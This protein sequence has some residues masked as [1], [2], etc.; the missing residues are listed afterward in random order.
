M[1]LFFKKAAAPTIL[2]AFFLYT[3]TLVD[4]S[5]QEDSPECEA[6]FDEAEKC[7]QSLM[8]IG[9]NTQFNKET[10]QALCQTEFAA[11]TCIQDYKT[12]CVKGMASMV[13]N[14]LAKKLNSTFRKPFLEHWTCLKDVIMSDN[15][16]LCTE[17]YH[18]RLEMIDTV[19]KKDRFPHHLL[20]L[21]RTARLFGHC[22]ARRLQEREV[23]RVGD[24]NKLFCHDWQSLEVCRANLPPEL[25]A[26]F[27][28]IGAMDLPT[29]ESSKKIKSF[30]RLL[31]HLIEVAG[32]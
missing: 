20:R 24:M 12:Q 8:I 6:K 13:F 2:L 1:F 21:L 11:I 16:K 14:L 19:E 28:K 26:A 9:K 17:H 22:T 4:L 29:A 18:L 27:T 3:T 10:F 30:L 32:H 5:F 25:G 7:F 31:K 23:H 15:A